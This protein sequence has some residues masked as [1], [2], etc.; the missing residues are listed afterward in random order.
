VLRCPPQLPISCEDDL[1]KAMGA[2]VSTSARSPGPPPDDAWFSQYDNRH[3]DYIQYAVVMELADGGSLDTVDYQGMLQLG[4]KHA[5]ALSQ[6]AAC[7][8]EYV[9]T[10]LSACRQGW[11]PSTSPAHPCTCYS[12]PAAPERAQGCKRNGMGMQ[13]LY[14]GLIQVLPLRYMAVYFFL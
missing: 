10:S 6:S 8:R 4:N 12:A 5:T 14:T 11:R 9:T 7:G 13:T 1:D 2:S 3:E